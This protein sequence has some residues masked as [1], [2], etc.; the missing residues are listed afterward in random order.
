MTIRCPQCG[1]HFEADDDAVER[2]LRSKSGQPREWVLR[3]E[4]TEV[5]RCALSDDGRLAP[6]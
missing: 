4:G 1:A 3:I 6:A 2:S 5:H